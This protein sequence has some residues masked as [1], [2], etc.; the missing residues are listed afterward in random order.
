MES[1]TC[2][3]SARGAQGRPV[4]IEITSEDTEALLNLNVRRTLPEFFPNEYRCPRSRLILRR[5]GGQQT[6]SHARILTHFRTPS[7][8]SPRMQIVVQVSKPTACQS[9]VDRSISAAF[10]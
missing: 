9:L 5:P 8:S 6:D 10:F 3:E 2:R 7:R 1:M 4:A